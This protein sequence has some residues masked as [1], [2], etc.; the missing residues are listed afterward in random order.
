MVFSKSFRIS[1]SYSVL[2]IKIKS[3]L[4]KLQTSKLTKN[5]AF[6]LLPHMQVTVFLICSAPR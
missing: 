1:K 5:N 2:A 6:A 4:I 3:K